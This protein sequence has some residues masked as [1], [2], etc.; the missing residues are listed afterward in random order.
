MADKKK[1]TRVGAVYSRV[2]KRAREKLKN[3]P[4]EKKKLREEE[5]KQKLILKD[6]GYGSQRGDA[7]NKRLSAIYDEM[8]KLKEKRA[9]VLPQKE[10]DKKLVHEYGEDAMR[11]KGFGTDREERFLAKGAL[12][13]PKYRHGH[14]DYRKGGVATRM[15]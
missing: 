1:G 15:K 12:I 8:Q 2:I 4:K 3:I 6:A 5:K 11:T 9:R 10:K 14:K 7:A 13:G